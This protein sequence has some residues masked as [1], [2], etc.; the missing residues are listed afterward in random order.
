MEELV[1]KSE[2]GN[3][4]TTSLLVARTF[5]KR[6]ADVLRAIDNLDCSRDFF[7]RNFAF[8]EN[9]GIGAVK[10]RI[11]YM[12][13]DGFSFLAMGFT[14]EKAAKFKEDYI[15]AFNQMEQTIRN[16]G[17]TVPSTFR[18]AL[19]LA[20]EQQEVIESQQ[21]LLTEQAPKV[22]FA[23]AVTGAD[24]NIL[25]RDLAK[26]IC[27]SGV[28]VGEVRLYEW[29][30]NNKYLIRRTRWSNKKQRYEADYTPTQIAADLKVFFMTENVITVGESSFIKHTVK[31]TPKGQQYFINKFITVELQPY[32]TGKG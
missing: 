22:R 13:K 2:K 15:N 26:L 32:E 30:V 5:G 9:Q 19:L 16:G 4:V 24:T 12:N 14:G 6:H 1:F 7:E 17:F 27:Q 23:E 31:I 18:E 11:C 20:A 21:R 25:M 28:N 3:P 10:E 29:M 8:V